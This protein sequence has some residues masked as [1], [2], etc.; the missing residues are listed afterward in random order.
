MRITKRIL[1]M[2]ISVMMILS[3]VAVFADGK[4]STTAF[5]D[6]LGDEAYAD[7]IVTLNL[8]GVINGY[9]DG[10]F[11]PSDNVT[12]A[13]FTA[14]LIR[15]LNLASA[16]SPSAA[17]LP[18]TD[19]DDNDSS[20]NWAIPCINTAYGMGVIN[21]YEDATFRP[22]NNVA[23]EEAIKMIVCTLGYGN[24]VDTSATPWYVDYIT[25]A[26]QIGLTE[27]A[28]SL[29]QAETP[30][31][32]ACI[33][34]LLYDALEIPLVES[35]KLTEKTI[36]SD[37]LGYIKAEGII[38]SDGVTSLSS[39]DVNLRDN[40]IQIY[41]REESGL[42]ETHT[43]STT[44]KTLK[45]YLG[46]GVDFY[47]T[48]KGSGV[49]TLMF[50]V[51]NDSLVTTI[52]ARYFDASQSTD[53]RIAY[54]EDDNAEKEKYITLD[55]NN[56]VI[57]N[58]KRYGAPEEASSF[59]K[60]MIPALGEIKF[61]DSDKDND[62]DV[63]VIKKYDAYYVS[64][65]AASTYEIIDNVLAHSNKVLE[66]NTATNDNLSIVNK[67]G[68]EVAYSSIALNNIVFY[69]KSME[70][71]GTVLETA[72]VT[73][74]KITGTVT[75]RSGR[76]K[77]T[78][79]GKEYKASPAA[80]WLTG[81]TLAEPQVE[82]AGTFYLDIN[83][84]IIAYTKT[85]TTE[86]VK[87]GFIQGYSKDPNSFDGEATF[88]IYT[89]NGSEEM[90]STCEDTRVNG[91]PC[92]TG[93]DV[94]EALADTQI[95]GATKRQQLIKYSTKTV[96]GKKCF[97]NIY[98]AQPVP[99]G[100]EVKSDKLT[101]LTTVVADENSKLTYT[102]S[103]SILSRTGVSIGVSGATV[104]SI[105]E[106][107]TDYKE[108]S[109]KTASEAFRNNGTYKVEVYDVSVANAA[110][111]VLLYGGSSEQA[112]DEL[113]PVYVYID[114]AGAINDNN[115][116]AYMMEAFKI[117]YTGSASKVTDEWVSVDSST[118]LEGYT[119]GDIFRT[120]L[121]RYGHIKLEADKL[122]YDADG[123]STYEEDG[124]MG[125]SEYYA[126]LGSFAAVD[127]EGQQISITPTSAEYMKGHPEEAS[128]KIATART[129]AFSKFSNAK[130]LMYETVEGK[131]E[132]KEYPYD[133]ALSMV[134]AYSPETTPSEVFI[135]MT[136]GSVKLLVIVKP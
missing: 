40:E 114:K 24:G 111:I 51:V 101:K 82:D 56:T 4:T 50:C 62:Y 104:I 118:L 116:N 132:V 102:S 19:V 100:A 53:T 27:N 17:E 44:D 77:F 45:D 72:V 65:K 106:T 60:A 129:F 99:A 25:R 107:L 94:I 126:I 136:N 83:G 67:S 8:M 28:S 7:A 127:I 42:Y 105:P 135:K 21:G 134:T 86:N 10:T 119:T 66:L 84:D 46:Y 87:Y 54:Y 9:P 31:S 11:K 14:M 92:A 1:A 20:I 93:A 79:S 81:G 52:N 75:A 113:S 115:K 88:R 48:T 128:A 120:G 15:T 41:A 76:G 49:R 69:A 39:P 110:K 73:S 71:G 112:V 23:Y 74:D 130:V 3:S 13:E 22:N 59:T 80:P 95:S 33:A 103:S 133:A 6:V 16:G 125:V 124:T 117:P 131:L 64:T 58:G 98:V 18:F 5:S 2:M 38:S 109:K 122:L 90:V 57:Y 108:Y 30:A 91:T 121:D 34:Q 70:N 12:R 85:A 89:A 43:Y 26:N 32:R 97:D 47:Y 36:L 55:T 123:N 96:N 78:I 29:G 68:A 63:V 35:D 37:Y 61:I